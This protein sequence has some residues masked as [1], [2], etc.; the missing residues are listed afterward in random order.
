MLGVNARCIP[1]LLWIAWL[2][3][4][5][6][7]L[8][9]EAA[10]PTAT[11]PAPPAL[12]AV[13]TLAGTAPASPTAAGLMGQT[14]APSGATA[15]PEATATRP[16]DLSTL[17]VTFP[18]TSPE[19]ADFFNEIA[20]P[21]DIALLPQAHLDL[22]PELTAG[23]VRVAFASWMEAQTALPGLAGEIEIVTYNPE[24]WE[25]TPQAEK[26]NL[27]A[28]VQNAAEFARSLGLEFMVTPDRRFATEHLPELAASADIL[29]LQGQRLQEDPAA[30][31]AWMREMIQAARMSN[32]ELEVFVQVGTTQG[33]A[34]EMYR[35]IQTVAGEIDGI[36]VWAT[37]A[38]LDELVEFIALIR[39]E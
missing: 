25:Q 31:E 15:S 23:Q 13:S 27:P 22:L 7:L 3:A 1:L 38:T 29:G 9:E 24:H 11:S 32:P 34:E 16:V 30:F 33:S 10:P 36:S 26:E 19:M 18:I 12:T 8:Q 21:E 28:T 6:S 5:C 39:P 2:S 20:R 4:A 17:P 37:P 14:A 35:S